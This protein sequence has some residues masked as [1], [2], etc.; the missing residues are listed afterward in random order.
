MGSDPGITSGSRADPG[1][2]RSRAGRTESVC[3][4]SFDTQI[5][6]GSI[7]DSDDNGGSICG[8]SSA[9]GPICST[10]S[11]PD[12]DIV[13]GND[14][15]SVLGTVFVFI[16]WLN[17]IPRTDFVPRISAKPVRHSGTDSACGTGPHSRCSTV[18][19]DFRPSVPD[20]GSQSN[21]GSRAGVE[22]RTGNPD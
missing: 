3:A 16:P 10:S 7:R 14:S 2:T 18:G 5:C 4:E 21:T 12:A 9:C 22:P 11:A 8:T 20:H 19:R 13:P 1:V 17:P 15:N 6:T